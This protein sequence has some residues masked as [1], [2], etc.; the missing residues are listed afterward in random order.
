MLK[1]CNKTIKLWFHC[2]VSITK[3]LWFYCV[4][5]PLHCDKQNSN[6]IM[7]PLQVLSY[8]KIRLCCAWPTTVPWFYGK[9]S[10]RIRKGIS[11]LIWTNSNRSEVNNNPKVST[12]IYHWAQTH[13]ESLHYM[14]KN[15]HASDSNCFSKI[16]ERKWFF[17]KSTNQ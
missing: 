15:I 9:D 4:V 3:K 10:L 12:L 14:S 6:R 11:P 17:F 8:N 2:I 13:D 1:G 5:I 16:N 7:I